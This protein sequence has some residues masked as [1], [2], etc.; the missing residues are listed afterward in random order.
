MIRFIVTLVIAAVVSAPLAFGHDPSGV[1]VGAHHAHDRPH[2]VSHH[3]VAS[4]A[5]LVEHDC[6][7][8]EGGLGAA[9]C[10]SRAGHCASAFLGADCSIS[11]FV[12]LDMN[13]MIP[14]NDISPKTFGPESETP[15]PRG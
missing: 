12:P 10:E 13:P 4:S 15:P 5:N 11:L 6:V 3:D 1:G 8:E 7:H 2:H 14:A 9:P